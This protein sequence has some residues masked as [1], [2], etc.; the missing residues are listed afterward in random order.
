MEA[1]EEMTS[2]IK[3]F[4]LDSCPRG[5]QGYKR[6]LLQLFGFLGH[7]KS[8]FI[9]TCK[10]VL[11]NGEYQNYI[12]PEEEG[13][14][15][16]HT[17]S[18]ISYPL[19]DT[20]ILVDNRGCPT[21]N[22]YET[23][24]IFAQLANLLPLDEAVEWSRGFRL[25]ERIVEAE[26]T[27]QP[28]DFIFPIFVFSV[29]NGLN[30]EMIPDIKKLLEFARDLT[31][32]F[33]VVVLTHKTH[34]DFLD[35]KTKFKNMGAEQI[36]ALENFTQEDQLKTRGRHENVLKFFC[37]VLTEIQFRMERM[38]DPVA[39]REKRKIRVLKFL[40]DREIQ[41]KEMEMQMKV[42]E[43]EEKQRVRVNSVRNREKS[44]NKEGI[45]T[46]N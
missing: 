26:K 45:C 33:P 46:L 24:E 41:I 10:Y 29:K 25:Q 11:E 5:N 15:G 21:M 31:E 8:S 44:D 23:G 34:C 7:G 35:V 14:G 20:L 39:L 18:R 40:Y 36:F 12:K 43:L 32:I 2:H 22:D 17:M 13:D 16:A 28:S 9:N 4:S 1:I 37:E 38:G 6:V 19:T 27:V 42:R 3:S 30:G